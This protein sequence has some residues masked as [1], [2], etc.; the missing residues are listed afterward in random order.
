MNDTAMLD[1]VTA[2]S[3]ADRLRIIGLLSQRTARVAEIAADLNIPLRDA[4]DH[5]AF[6]AQVE[7]LRE[8]GGVYEL[9]TD[10]LKKLAREQFHETRE[11]YVP[12]PE[13]DQKARKILAT[14]LNPDGAIKQIP[15]QPAKLRVILDF[16]VSSFTPGANYTE[17]E[18]NMILRRFHLD[19]AGLRR[20]LVDAGM[21]KR[22][23]D[24]SRYWRESE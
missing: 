16:I 11:A 5:L 6:L 8:T 19:T 7:V 21:L 3:D 12:A 2:L 22:L 14:Y 20:D 24:G 4:F 9:Q 15:S 17:K 18:V 1:F 10:G 13:L 23:S